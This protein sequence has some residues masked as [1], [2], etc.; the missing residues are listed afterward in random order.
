MCDFMYGSASS[1]EE[2]GRC[3]PDGYCRY[4]V[5]RYDSENHRHISDVKDAHLC[6]NALLLRETFIE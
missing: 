1:R 5:A 2:K 4:S 3:S 6:E